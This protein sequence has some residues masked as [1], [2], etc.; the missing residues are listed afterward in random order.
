LQQWVS[1]STAKKFLVK[2]GTYYLHEE[3]APDG[4]SVAEDIKF[5]VTSDLKLQVEENGQWVDVENSTV[6]MEDD[7][8]RKSETLAAPEG[9]GETV[10]EVIFSKTSVTGQSELP[11]A[12]LRIVNAEGQTVKRWT[13]SD[14][15][16]VFELVP[17][18][19]VMHEDLAPLGYKLANDIRFRVTEDLSVET[20]VDNEW[21]KASEYT[22]HMVDEEDTYTKTET[23][24]SATPSAPVVT[25]PELPK[26]GV[27]TQPALATT[28]GKVSQTL[29]ILAVTFV[30]VGGLIYALRRKFT[31]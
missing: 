29:V 26:T 11:G 28:G 21:V 15:T 5:R 3:I 19:Y 27:D 12:S 25:T 2:E 7:Q 17:G 6:H 8:V 1:E 13:S 31:K 4:Y 30:V 24:P 10:T 22:I 9:E 23:S 18:E 20:F 16:Y 14:I